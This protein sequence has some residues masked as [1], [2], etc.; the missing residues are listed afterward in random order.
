MFGLQKATHV[1]P[2]VDDPG[3]LRWLAAQ[4]AYPERPA[5][6]PC[7]PRP[8]LR[9]NFVSSIDGAVTFDNRSA[10]L[11]GP[12]DHAIFRVLRGLADLVLVG[13]RTAVAEGYVVPR[14]D[15]VFTD[16]RS[17]R[18]QRS[19]PAL[20][21]VSR[22]LSIPDDYEPLADPSTVVF[23]CRFAPDDRRAALRAA[24]ATL[25]D[26]GDE[27]VDLLAVLDVCA[28]RGWLEVLSEGGPTLL[29]SFIDADVL[30][31]LCV[32]TSPNVV[33]G[34]AGRIAHHPATARLHPMHPTTILTDDDGF[35][36]TRWT[37]K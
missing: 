10:G 12:G 35:V 11:A 17:A 4:Y 33:A 18:G 34:D 26:C 27:A 5:S 14:P 29:G 13:A 31:E 6:P 1:T 21:L 15:D 37:R 8:Y 3:T 16:A 20:G 25:V 7:L 24:G 36:F 32:T 22:S 9:A 23:T 19:A 30:D 28:E 2:G